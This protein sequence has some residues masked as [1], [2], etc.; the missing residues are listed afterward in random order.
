M[1]LVWVVP[2]DRGGG[3]VWVADSCCRQAVAEG[4]DARLLTLEHLSSPTLRTIAYPC[5]SM[6]VTPPYTDTPA[7]FLQ[8]VEVNSPTVVFLNNVDTMDCCIPYLPREVRCVYVVH[9]TMS[10]YW[11]AAVRHEA[12]LDAIVAVSAETASRFRHKL[13][14]PEKLHV[15]Q[16]GTV[17]PPLPNLLGNPRRPDLVFLGGDDPRKGAYDVL[18]L[19]PRLVASGWTGE[20][21][22]FGRLAGEFRARVS[23]LPAHSRIQV[24]G[25]VPRAEVFRKLGAS[26]AMLML[27][28]AE[29]CSIALLEGMAMGCVPVA[30]DIAGTGTKE[31]VP[32]GQRFL[33]SLSDFDALTQQVHAAIEKQESLASDLAATARSNFS[34]SRMWRQYAEMIA[35]MGAIPSAA[36]PLAGSAAPVYKPPLRASHLVPLTI[37]KWLRPKI[38][39]SGRIYY[40]LRNKL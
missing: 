27:S 7:R 1:R 18:A 10:F 8:W 14:S 30:W 12:S 34:E 26:S 21:H 31:I 6:D 15:I 11:R 38:A 4:F 32:L 3:V 37:W 29:A 5:E 9:D 40:F 36:R 16:N 35:S 28:R 39:Q 23:A 20:L 25:H 17:F 2:G 13:R 19:W 33:A 24:H 22:W